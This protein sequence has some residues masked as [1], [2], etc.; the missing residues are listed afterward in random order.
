MYQEAER[1][2]E[3]TAFRATITNFI[4]RILV[5]LS[6]V[7]IV[8]ALPRGHAEVVAFGWG[9]LLLAVIR[10]ITAETRGA[11]PLLEVA[12]HIGVAFLVIAVIR[13]IGEWISWWLGG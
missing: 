10:Y 5:A 7:E 2:E 12:K 8:L 11:R 3:R 13:I 6:F 1:L 9:S 4:A